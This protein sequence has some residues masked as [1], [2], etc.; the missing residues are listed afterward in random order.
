MS[1]LH[2]QIQH[3]EGSCAVL[4]RGDHPGAFETRMAAFTPAWI[5]LE[6]RL[7]AEHEFG[8]GILPQP[9]DRVSLV[10]L[11]DRLICTCHGFTALLAG[12]HPV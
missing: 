8:T 3:S 5:A 12:K 4:G 1:F 7:M 6:M 9:D 10:T 11:P 2:G